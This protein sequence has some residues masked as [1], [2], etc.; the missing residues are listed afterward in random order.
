MLLCTAYQ[1]LWPYQHPLLIFFWFHFNPFKWTVALITFYLSSM[2]TSNAFGYFFLFLSFNFTFCH[3]VICERHDFLPHNVP[4]NRMLI[5]SLFL[6][7]LPGAFL[8]VIRSKSRTTNAAQQYALKRCDRSIDR[9][10]WSGGP[11][12]SGV[13]W[14]EPLK[15][16]PGRWLPWVVDLKI[17]SF[18]TFY[19]SG[20][21]WVVLFSRVT[22][23]M[24]YI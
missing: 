9:Y 1:S 6:P 4:R 7:E 23:Y 2:L 14:W 22:L 20:A 19:L 13:A 17:E 12:W 8:G 15:H 5:D 16:R 10:D 24:H 11:S 3:K 18:D 21:N